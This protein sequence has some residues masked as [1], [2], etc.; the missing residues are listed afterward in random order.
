MATILTRQGKLGTSFVIH[1][2][3]NDRKSR[4]YLCLGQKYRRRQAEEIKILVE[5]LL[6][7]AATKRRLYPEEEEAVRRLPVDL[8]KRITEKG[9]LVGFQFLSVGEIWERYLDA[10][11]KDPRKKPSTVETYQTA[12]KRFLEY[13]EPDIEPDD[14]ELTDGSDWRD[15]LEDEFNLSEASAASTIVRTRTVFAWAQKNGY[16]QGNIFLNVRK[17]STENKEREFYVPM[18]WFEK[19]MTFCPD[20][21]WRVYLALMRIGGVRMGE[22]HALTWENVLWNEDKVRIISPK[23][24]RFQGHDERVIPFFPRLRQELQKLYHTKDCTKTGP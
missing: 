17:G 15:W 21:E 7:A 22:A 20:Q 10:S 2:Y 24:E 9:L 8:K 16:C 5:N 14:I 3:G 23:T 6:D 1:Y 11:E 4:F 12:S 13:F 19:V 18:E